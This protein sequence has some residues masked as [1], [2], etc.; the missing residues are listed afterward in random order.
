[1]R[2][3]VDNLQ[4]LLRDPFAQRGRTPFREAAGFGRHY[5]CSFADFAAKD[6][7]GIIKETFAGRLT[8]NRRS[9]DVTASKREARFGSL[10]GSAAAYP[11]S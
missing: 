4:A 1:M 2:M 3:L 7:H 10:R 9:P 5:S 11:P 6:K 8:P